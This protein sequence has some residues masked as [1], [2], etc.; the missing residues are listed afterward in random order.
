MGKSALMFQLA[1][2]L[3]HTV[4][5]DVYSL[6]MDADQIRTRLIAGDI[7]TSLSNIQKGLVDAKKIEAAKRRLKDLKYYIDD[8]GG[9]SINQLCDEAIQRKQRI[10]TKVIIVD[11]LQLMRVEKGHSKDDEVGKITRQLK[12]LA[13]ELKCPVI[14]GSQ[15]N[16]GCETRGKETGDYRPTLADL[17]ESGNIEQ[18]A[19][20]VMF[21][22]RESRFTGE[23]PGEADLIIAKNRNGPV[24]DITMQFTESQTRFI[25]GG[26]NYEI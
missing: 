25:D 17:R 8:R 7:N 26:A 18:D 14:V 3:S 19:D 22:H 16:R 4:P 2:N 13:K 20:M 11:Y 1:Y 6:E 10:G 5:V 24:G 15:L 12:E 23:R 9:L 21:V